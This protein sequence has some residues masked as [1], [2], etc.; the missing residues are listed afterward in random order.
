MKI[1]KRLKLNTLVSFFITI[2]MAISLFWSFWGI[3]ETNQNENLVDEIRKT[4]FERIALRDDYLLNREERAG[5]QWQIKSEALRKLLDAAAQR[6]T[7]KEQKIMLQEMRHNYDVTFS[8]FSSI[9]KKYKRKDGDKNRPLA[10]NEADSRLIGQVFLKSYALIDRIATLHELSKKATLNALN[11]G[12]ILIIFFFACGITAIVINSISLNKIVAKGVNALTD[13]IKVIGGGNLDYQIA[14]AGDDELADLAKAVNETVAKL[15]H[16]YTSVENLQRE[17]SERKKLEEDLKKIFLHQQTLLDAIPDIIMEVDTNKIYTW[18]NEP[19]IKFFGKDVIGK[20]ADSYFVREQDTYNKVQRLF[21]GSNDLIY[22]E[23]WQKRKDGQERLLAWWCRVLKDAQGKISGALS[24]ARDIT[25]IKQTEEEIKILN[26]ELEQRV[27]ERTAELSAKTAEL[28]KI[29]KV[30]VDRE[31]RMRE[32]K[33]RIAE[34]E[35]IKDV[36]SKA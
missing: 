18:A 11:R 16:S 3:Y 6:F 20:A 33:E 26:E 25:T 8:V 12:A 23:S 10:F 4:S 31:L 21:N 24:S 13:G 36:K 14:V 1:A 2:L 9:L 5:I 19:G 29:N 35:G 27:N 15:K 30:F 22:L 32:L 34:L 28:E 17:I 7:S